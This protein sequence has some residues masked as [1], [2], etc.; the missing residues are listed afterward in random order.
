[1]QNN[2]NTVKTLNDCKS[3]I[4]S[5][6]GLAIAKC[7]YS[8]NGPPPAPVS[9]SLRML[10]PESDQKYRPLVSTI[11]NAIETGSKIAEVCPVSEAVNLAEVAEK[12]NLPGYTWERF[13]VDTIR[14]I[15][16]T[17][18]ARGMMDRNPQVISQAYSILNGDLTHLTHLTDLNDL[19]SFNNFLRS[20][21]ANL[22]LFNATSDLAQSDKKRFNGNLLGE[23]RQYVSDNEGSFT[24]KDLDT[25]LGIHHQADKNI[26]RQACFLLL[27]ERKIRKD[28]RVTGK[29]H[30]LRDDINFIDLNNTETSHFPISLPLGLDGMVNIPTKSIIVIAGTSNAGKTALAMEFLKNNIQQQYPLFYLMS[31]MGPSEYKN[32]VEKTHPDIKTWNQRVAAA[33]I[34]TGFDGVIMHHNQDGFTVVDFLEDVGGEYYKIA[35]DIRGIYDALSEGVALICLQKK[36]A[37]DYGRGGEATTEKARLYLTIDVLHHQPRC[38]ISAIKIIKA[39]DY[40]GDNPNGKEIHVKITAGAKIEAISG[41]MYCNQKQREQYV[42]QYQHMLDKGFETMPSGEKKLNYRMTLEDGTHGNILQK[43]V[44]KW[45]ENMPDID[46]KSLLQWLERKT[47]DG[48]FMLTRKSWFM[49]VA[50][51]LSKKQ[52]QKA[53]ENEAPF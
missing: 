49:Q 21:N 23:I 43:D 42:K 36:T 26:R 33:D 12:H 20:F 28:K 38:T 11:I 29:Y 46:V 22:T 16:E 52:K 24:V 45:Q 15:A 37:S 3:E 47:K 9:D 6:A 30:I 5:L 8:N 25:W 50:G 17:W 4:N 35:S 7:F 2:D 10:L 31:E 53:E 18:L 13:V 41:W 51:I 34:C 1:M 48:D 32:R 39:K 40:N 27:R 14:I 44:D 19:T